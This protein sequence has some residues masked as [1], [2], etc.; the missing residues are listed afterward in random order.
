MSMTDPCLYLIYINEASHDEAKRCFMELLFVSNLQMFYLDANCFTYQKRLFFKDYHVCTECLHVTLC[1]PCLSKYSVGSAVLNSTPEG[2]EVITELENEVLDIRRV[3]KRVVN[4]GAEPIAMSYTYINVIRKWLK[5]K[6]EAYESWETTHNDGEDFQNYK[7]PGQ[8]FVRLIEE[9]C[10]IIKELEG[11]LLPAAERK[12]RFAPMDRKMA[13]LF[14]KY[15][16]DGD[17]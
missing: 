7:R 14:R 15:K 6:I 8:D 5:K 9:T 17:S 13:D 16:I 12:S 2:F 4:F 10:N 11:H 3:V 1:K